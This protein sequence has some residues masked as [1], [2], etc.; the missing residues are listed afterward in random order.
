[1]ITSRPPTAVTTSRV[2]TPAAARQP[3]DGLGDDARVHDFAFDNR[4]GEQRRDGDFD[5]LGLGL[6]MIDHGHFDE[7]GTDIETHRGLLTAKKC[8]ELSPVPED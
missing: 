3:G 2:V 8:H 4:V 7:A 1:M 5:E 6:G